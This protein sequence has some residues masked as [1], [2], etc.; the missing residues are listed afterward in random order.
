MHPMTSRGNLPTEKRAARTVGLLWVLG[1]VLAIWPF[2]PLAAQTAL[3]FEPHRLVARGKLTG[4]IY[5][6]ADAAA[7]EKEAAEALAFWM[8]RV[9]GATAEIAEEPADGLHPGI[10]LGS[11][12]QAARRKIRAAESPGETWRWETRSGRTLFLLG[13]KPLATRLAVGDFLQRELGVWFLFPG[14]WGAEWEPRRTLDFPRHPRSCEPAFWWRSLGMANSPAQ[15]EWQRNNGLGVR[16]PF[17]HALHTIFTKETFAEYPEFFPVR[18]RAA[19]QSGRAGGGKLRGG[20]G[21]GVFCKRSCRAHFRHGHHRQ[22]DL[23]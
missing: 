19:A 18:L 3:A 23:G 17:S 11:T 8:R 7:E 5:L 4:K 16:P 21:G 10:Y 9:T 12:R 1:L 14:E 13:N 2:F 15:R 22:H 20:E 6:P